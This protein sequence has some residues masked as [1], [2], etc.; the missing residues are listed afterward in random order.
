MVSHIIAARPNFIKANHVIKNLYKNGLENC[1]VHT[2][3]HYDYEMSQIFFQE[4][5][6]P[7]PDFNLGIRSGSHGEQTGNAI[8]A[9]EKNLKETNPNLVVVYGDVNSSLAAAIAAS[10]LNI[11]VF[12]VESGCRSFD[13]TMPEEI[14]RILIDNI[15]SCLFCTEDS[16][17]DNLISEGFPNEMIKLVGNTAI[18][19]LNNIINNHVID[20]IPGKYYLATFHRPFNVDNEERL[21][22]LLKRVNALKYPV[23]IPAHPR[24]KNK[25]K[26]KYKNIQFIKPL[27]YLDFI[28]HIKSSEGVISDSGGIQCECAYLGVPLL[29]V[30]PSTEHIL[31]LSYGNKLVSPEGIYDESFTKVKSD[32]PKMWDGNASKRIADIIKNLI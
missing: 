19:S 8:I 11:P 2:N 16:A 24:L 25:I 5:E 15:S 17:R 9:I 31:S 32:I 10:K 20:E 6:I 28:S 7:K 13:R 18:D 23:V 29:T 27:G 1:I 26:S 14:N 30:R 4:L 22:K 21:N 3:Q 12:H